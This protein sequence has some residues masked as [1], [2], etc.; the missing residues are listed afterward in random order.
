MVIFDV[1][2]NGK[3]ERDVEAD[4][5]YVAEG[6]FIFVDENGNMLASVVCEKGVTVV[7]RPFNGKHRMP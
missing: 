4:E 2:R 3:Y 7:K 1:I 6:A 5:F